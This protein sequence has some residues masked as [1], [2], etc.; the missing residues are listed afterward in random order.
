MKLF[1][2]A[3]VDGSY[4]E[5]RTPEVSENTTTFGVEVVFELSA[6]KSSSSSCI[7]VVV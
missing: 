1:M 7:S 3:F 2:L 4:P 6:T 5:E